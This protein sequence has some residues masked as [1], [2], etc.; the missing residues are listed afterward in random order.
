MLCLRF[1]F[2]KK[3]KKNLL[4][5]PFHVG[6]GTISGSRALCTGP[7]TYLTS[8]YFTGMC[9]TSGSRALFTGPTN[10]FFS[11]FFIKNRSHGTI[12]TFKNYFTTV[13]LVP[14][15]PIGDGSSLVSS[16]I[17]LLVGCVFVFYG[18]N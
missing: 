9:H 6:H 10:L 15:E 18:G 8:K 11:Y 16:C 17:C 1:P 12:Y 14:N 4:R 2:F 7:T 3:K 5:P 13:F